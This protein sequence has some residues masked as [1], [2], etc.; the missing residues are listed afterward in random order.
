MLTP[1]H[2]A[3]ARLTG[4]PVAP[5]TPQNP[6]APP[7]DAL[8][9]SLTLPGE[10]HSARIAR[11]TVRLALLT[12]RLDGLVPA[13]EQVTGEMVA[14][15]WRLNPGRDL[16]LSLRWRDDALRLTVYDGHAPHEHPRLAAA[17]EA[18]RRSALRLLSVVVRECRGQ[19]GFGESREPGGGTRTWATLPTTP[20][21]TYAHPLRR[22]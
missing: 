5:P 7:P 14:A 3:P 6:T 11:G 19:W 21:H 8:A 20:T 4:C 12:H 10:A 18:R 15:A 9:C 1:F 16:Y 2:P 22:A 17:C 13:A